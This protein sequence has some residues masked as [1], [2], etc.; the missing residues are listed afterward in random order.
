MK[1]YAKLFAYQVAD[2][3]LDV[4]PWLDGNLICDIPNEILKKSGAGTFEFPP[5]IPS[6]NFQCQIQEEESKSFTGTYA[7]RVFDPVQINYDQNK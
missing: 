5:P 4:E 2:M 6:I 1:S 3:F 7:H